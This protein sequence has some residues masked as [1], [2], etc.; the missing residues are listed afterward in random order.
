M[1]PA[2]AIPATEDSATALAVIASR[3]LNFISGRSPLLL[4]PLKPLSRQDDR[5]PL[6]LSAG[7]SGP[8]QVT[9]LFVTRQVA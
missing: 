8:L 7:Q 1:A 3:W 4:M 2:E 9:A 5:E 6:L